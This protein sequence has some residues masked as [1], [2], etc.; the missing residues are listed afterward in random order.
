M[1]TERIDTLLRNHRARELAER[2]VALEDEVE[3]LHGSIDTLVLEEVISSGKAR[4]LLNMKVEEQRELRRK[5]WDLEIGMDRKN[6]ILEDRIDT[7]ERELAA[8]RSEGPLA[9]RS[10]VKS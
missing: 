3:R 5:W 7:L 1:S 8:V 9:P 6:A 2:V 10:Q 4:E